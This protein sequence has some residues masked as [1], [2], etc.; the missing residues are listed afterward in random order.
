MELIIDEKKENPLLKRTEIKFKVKFDKMRTPSRDEVKEL[1]SKNLNIPKE[2]IILDHMRTSFGIHLLSGY[3]K[4]YNDVDTAKK[5]EPDYILIRNGL[6][7]PKK[8]GE[9]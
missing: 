8:K 5:I 3:C 1:L 9:K 6:K 2:R 7:E 4:V